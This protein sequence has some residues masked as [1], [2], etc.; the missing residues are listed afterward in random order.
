MAHYL[1]KLL[2][3]QGLS[4][5]EIYENFSMKRPQMSVVDYPMKKTA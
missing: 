3:E 5:D 2:E 4:Y 1:P